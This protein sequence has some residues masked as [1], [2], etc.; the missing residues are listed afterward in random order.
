MSNLLIQA[1]C[2]KLNQSLKFPYQPKPDKYSLQLWK[3]FVY[4]T[5]CNIQ[6]HPVS[7]EIIFHLTHMASSPS[8]FD[9]LQQDDC[10]DLTKMLHS[11]SITL[12]AKFESLPDKF[13]HILGNLTLPDDDGLAFL[14]ALRDRDALLASDGSFLQTSY[15]GTHTYKLISKSDMTMHIPGAA[16]SP[17]SNKM[18]SAPTEH[19]GAITVLV[20]LIVLTEHHKVPTSK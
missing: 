8:S 18:S 5:F 16:K 13:H 1:Q 6:H 2:P 7:G 11:P 15:A 14:N 17:N 20:V 10:A 4:R 9:I 3:E 12:K 19:Y